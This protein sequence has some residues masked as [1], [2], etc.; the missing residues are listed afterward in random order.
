MSKAM[1][2]AGA[3]DAFTDGGM[4]LS[5]VRVLNMP[6]AAPASSSAASEETAADGQG[7][8]AEG[9]KPNSQESDGGSGTGAGPSPNSKKGGAGGQKWFDRDA[10]VNA[11]RRGL[12][13]S[14]RILKGLQAACRER[15]TVFRLA[16]MQCSVHH[17][18]LVDWLIVTG[19]SSQDQQTGLHLLEIKS[20]KMR[21]A[22]KA[23]WTKHCPS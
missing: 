6:V 21:V 23:R 19:L 7:Q 11:Q 8:G 18:V 17:G 15:G 22:S 16:F 12:R 3:G 13:N 1:I 9:T 2:A 20:K 14:Q 4:L 10:Q 5:D